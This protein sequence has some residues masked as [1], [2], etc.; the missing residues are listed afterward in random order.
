MVDLCAGRLIQLIDVH[1]AK[2]L[3][4][5]GWRGIGE[6]KVRK[7]L[8]GN[9]GEAKQATPRRRAGRPSTN[10]R[11]GE[12]HVDWPHRNRPTRAVQTGVRSKAV[13]VY[14]EH[15]STVTGLE[16]ERAGGCAP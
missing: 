3:W 7:H 14:G 10:R 6:G 11:R 8:H 5:R 1:G 16:L 15:R 13:E 2:P 4:G 9:G 12:S